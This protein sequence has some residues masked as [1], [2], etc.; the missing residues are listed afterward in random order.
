MKTTALTVEVPPELAERLRAYV[1]AGWAGSVDEVVTEATRR[2]LW[3]HRPEVI[4]RH[5]R[6][7]VAL[8]LR[9]GK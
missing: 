1:A 4:E 5:L 6:E 2:Y 7:D 9:E 3:S 8:A